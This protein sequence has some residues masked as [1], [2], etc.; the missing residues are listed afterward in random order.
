MH[1][2]VQMKEKTAK[3]FGVH[4]AT[5]VTIIIAFQLITILWAVPVIIKQNEKIASI[6]ARLA[7]EMRNSDGQLWEEF[8][9]LERNYTEYTSKLELKITTLQEELDNKEKELHDAETRISELQSIVNRNSEKIYESEIALAELAQSVREKEELLQDA[10]ALLE[11]QHN[12]TRDRVS[13]LESSHQELS[14]YLSLTRDDLNSSTSALQDRVEDLEEMLTNTTARTD[15]IELE[16]SSVEGNIDA[17]NDTKASKEAVTQLDREKV[18][19][20]EF[21][22]FSSDVRSLVDTSSTR[23]FHN[24]TTLDGKIRHLNMSLA[25]KADQSEVNTLSSRVLSIDRTTVNTYTFER[26]KNTVEEIKRDKADKTDLDQLHRSVNTLD[27]EKAK[28]SDLNDLERKLTEHVSASESSSSGLTASCL[29]TF[30][31]SV[32]VTL[33]VTLA[34]YP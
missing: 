2:L 4:L 26:L 27:S 14:T 17:L 6:E 30:T 7:K 5:V 8:Q 16:M 34:I 31:L 33:K 19:R 32:T 25:T 29:V 23:L 15:T 1:W 3:Q 10:L 28:K 12:H 20:T 18:D 21:E 22:H 9:Q 11:Q 13:T 24:L